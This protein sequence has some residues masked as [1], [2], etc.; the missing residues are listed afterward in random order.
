MFERLERED[1]GADFARL[2]IPNEFNLAFVVEED[3]P[4]FLW[5]RLASFNQLDEV[6]LLRVG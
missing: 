4:V 3:E 6:A 5:Q 2:A 1:G